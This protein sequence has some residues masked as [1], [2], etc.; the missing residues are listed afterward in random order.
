MTQSGFNGGG[1]AIAA[2]VA[3]GI[4]LAAFFLGI[5]LADLTAPGD[6]VRLIGSFLFLLLIV[7]CWGALP[8]LVFGGLVLA[9]I[10]RVPWGG[11]PTA[12]VFMIAGAF[13]AGVYV[14]AGLGVAGVSPGAAML[15]APWATP[16]LWGPSA[17]PE[18]WW[19][20]ASL[21]LA[22]AGAGLIYSTFAKRG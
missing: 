7:S 6:I 12:A 16:D 10:Q 19:L 22:G 15:F 9:V 21:L 11:Q 3:P 20:V 1:F 5:G 14:L 18:D 13:A 4:A 17:G 2:F 8:S